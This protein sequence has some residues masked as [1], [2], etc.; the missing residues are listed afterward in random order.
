MACP[1]GCTLGGWGLQG[2]TL[3]PGS[4]RMLAMT[5]Q[6]AYVLVRGICAQRDTSWWA[7][8]AEKVFGLFVLP[9]L[10]ACTCMT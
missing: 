4:L 9:E 3:L 5:C 10:L 1:T 2:E 6:V 7:T 8:A